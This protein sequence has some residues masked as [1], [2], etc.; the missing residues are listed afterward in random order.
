MSKNYSTT[1]SQFMQNQINQ[2]AT[3]S[4]RTSA[5]HSS[6]EKQSFEHSGKGS[7]HGDNVDRSYESPMQDWAGTSDDL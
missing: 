2:G 7:I 6:E 3:K 1:K 4:E 5:W